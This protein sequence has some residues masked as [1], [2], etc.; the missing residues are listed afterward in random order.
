MTEKKKDSIIPTYPWYC[1]GGV[2]TENI[3]YENKA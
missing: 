1:S 3:D 2:R